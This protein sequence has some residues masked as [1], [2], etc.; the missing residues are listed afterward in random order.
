MLRT[1]TVGVAAGAT[2][3]AAAVGI[4]LAVT[5]SAHAGPGKGDGTASSSV[6]VQA[7]AGGPAQ[8]TVSTAG[9]RA[10]GTATAR[11]GSLLGVSCVSVTSCTAVGTTSGGYSSGGAPGKTLAERW[12]GRAWTVQPTVSPPHGGV[13]SAVTCLSATDCFAVGSAAKSGK[14]AKTLPLAEH[15]D[16]RTWTV[17]PT[18]RPAKSGGLRGVSCTSRTFC[19]AEGSFDNPTSGTLMERWNGRA[20][21]LLAN[22]KA[23]MAGVSCVSARWCL[24]AGSDVA[25]DF[26]VWYELWHGSAWSGLHSPKNEKDLGGSLGVAAVTCTSPTACTEV[27]SDFYNDYHGTAARWDG[28]RWTQ[29]LTYTPGAAQSAGLEAVSCPSAT[30]CVAVGSFNNQAG[31]DKPLTEWWHGKAWAGL[32]SVSPPGQSAGL[33][34]ISCRSA[35]ACLA[36]GDTSPSRPNAPASP[37]AQWWNGTQWTVVSP[38]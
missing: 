38:H 18:A 3:V 33:F 23:L 11:H 34:A 5:I 10:T 25:V 37:M 9:Y 17:Q 1:R 29:Q 24:A 30:S 13:L 31:L 15:W 27:G 20:W 14:D 4:A 2:A 35:G 7:W 6:P 19:L 36:V 12:N 21:A 16:G 22:P 32:P 28:T 26:G 8:G